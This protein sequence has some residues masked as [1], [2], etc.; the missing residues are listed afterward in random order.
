[1]IL[2]RAPEPSDV[3]W[4]NLNVSFV[5]RIYKMIMIFMSILILIGLCFASIYGLDVVQ[6]QLRKEVEIDL[7]D[8]IVN[9]K[10]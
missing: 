8:G 9:N 10:K 5:S 2:E 3:L 7:E 1:M 4:E 6:R